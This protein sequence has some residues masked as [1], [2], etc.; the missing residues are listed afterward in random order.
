[1]KPHR[2]WGKKTGFSDAK[3][4]ENPVYYVEGAHLA[5]AFGIQQAACDSGRNS[6]R[7]PED[8]AILTG[9][10]DVIGHSLARFLLLTIPAANK[11][12]DIVF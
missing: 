3:P 11:M 8:N 2:Y 12:P 1:M 4:S 9:W 10:G 7:E 6:D 5:K